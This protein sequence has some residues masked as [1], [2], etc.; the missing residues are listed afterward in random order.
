MKE[1]HK[2]TKDKLLTTIPLLKKEWRIS[3]DF[4]ASGFSGLAQVLHLTTGGK[5]AGSGAK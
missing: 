3:F 5:G 4:I 2:I 1:E